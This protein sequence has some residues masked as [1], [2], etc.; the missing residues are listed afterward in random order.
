MHT[1]YVI[2]VWDNRIGYGSFLNFNVINNILNN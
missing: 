2:Q 1:N